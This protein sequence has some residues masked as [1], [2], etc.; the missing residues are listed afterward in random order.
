VF[1]PSAVGI[2]TAV[3]TIPNNTPGPE[4]TFTFTVSGEGINSFPVATADANLAY[5]KSTKTKLI[6]KTG[7]YKVSWS[8]DV[9]N[10]GPVA[11]EGAVV[12]FY[13][14]TD[15]F[16]S[17]ADDELVSTVEIKSQ[18]APK[19]EK[20]AKKKTA[21]FKGEFPQ[22]E[23]RIFAIV[24]LLPLSPAELDVTNNMVYDSYFLP[25]P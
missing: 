6:K 24:T 13:H 5:T 4:G 22:P 19:P 10:M 3:I 11:S 14:S 7:Q 8:V 17:F 2:R 18:P 20:K 9:T 16:F 21:K 23:G 12:K 25:L 15:E 1:N